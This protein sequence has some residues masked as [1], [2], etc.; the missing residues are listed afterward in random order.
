ML[1]IY[2]LSSTLVLST[3]DITETKR[4]IT[5]EWVISQTNVKWITLTKRLYEKFIYTF[6]LTWILRT[7]LD[8]ILTQMNNENNH[9]LLEYSKVNFWLITPIRGELRIT[10]EDDALYLWDDLSNVN[11]KVDITLQFTPIS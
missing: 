7:D 5:N 4:G 6:V 11:R 3:L 1:K 9:C 10:D 8:D 2:D